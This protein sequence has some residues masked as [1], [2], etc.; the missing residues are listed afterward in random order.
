[1]HTR[2]S[3]RLYIRSYREFLDADIAWQ[4]ALDHAALYV[5]QARTRLSWQI[6]SPGSH[7]R[8]LYEA[9][10]RAV[11]RLALARLKARNAE[12]RANRMPAEPPRLPSY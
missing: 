1:M 8:A 3:R 4:R 2:V 10:N 12:A 7:I 11:E 9:R 6:G 5:P